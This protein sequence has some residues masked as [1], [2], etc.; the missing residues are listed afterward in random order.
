MLRNQHQLAVTESPSWGGLYVAESEYRAPGASEVIDDGFSSFEDDLSWRSCLVS[1]AD[2]CALNVAL[3]VATDDTA[4]V[5]L[6]ARPASRIRNDRGGFE[7]G[8]NAVQ[9]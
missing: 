7:G 4:E 1:G 5:R 9:R 2:A 8:D 6:E 3:I